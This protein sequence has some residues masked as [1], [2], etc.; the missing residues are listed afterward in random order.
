MQSEPSSIPLVGATTD[1]QF[2][3]A[4]GVLDITLSPSQI[5]LLNNTKY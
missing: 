2:F 4:M 1:D 3:E 5:E